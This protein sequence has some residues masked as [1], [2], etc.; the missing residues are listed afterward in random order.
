MTLRALAETCCHFYALA[1]TR[2]VAGDNDRQLVKGWGKSSSGN[3]NGIH[4]AA[5][6][7][8][9]ELVRTGVCT[10]MF[11]RA[12][13]TTRGSP[14]FFPASD[15]SVYF[16]LHGT[17]RENADKSHWW[18][19]AN[20]CNQIFPVSQCQTQKNNTHMSERFPW[21]VSATKLV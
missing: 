15:S 20:S 1:G 10:R 2:T 6:P 13:R 8:Q 18:L 5:H 17:T 16:Y 19:N 9:L 4:R 14:L 21:M 12:F 7:M 3:I 11:L